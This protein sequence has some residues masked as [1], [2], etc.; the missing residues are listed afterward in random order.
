MTEMRL[1]ANNTRLE[2][3]LNERM[4]SKTMYFRLPSEAFQQQHKDTSSL[5]LV[6]KEDEVDAKA[7]K[8]VFTWNG[9]QWR[10]AFNERLYVGK[11]LEEVA[12]QIG[13]TDS[14]DMSG[15]LTGFFV[16][17]VGPIF[18]GFR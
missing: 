2:D 7:K 1:L 11:T 3:C 10:T 6:L 18:K 5:V 16:A 13:F 9:A 15:V 4:P 14:H 17:F 8:L 12:M